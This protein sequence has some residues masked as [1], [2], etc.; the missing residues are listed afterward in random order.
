MKIYKLSL[1]AAAL[2]LTAACSDIDDIKPEGEY[3]SQAQLTESNELAESRK[4]A[5]F[6]GMFTMM[7]QPYYTYG[8]SSDRADDFGFIMSAL[9]N[10]AEG[11]DLCYPNSGY[12]WFSVCGDLT[13]RTS[14]YANLFIRY[15]TPYNQMKIANDLIVYYADSVAVGNA[16][17]INKTAQARAIRAFDYMA[18]APYYQFTY[19][20]SKDK[21]CVPLVTEETTDFTDN[22]RATVEEIYTQVM[23]D[24]DYAIA[25][26]TEDRSDKSRINLNV[27]YGLRARANLVM[28]NYADAAADAE[29]AADGFTPATISEV[30]TPAFC[31][32]SEHN[33]IWGIDMVTA[34]TNNAYATSSSWLS[35]FSSVSYTA[36]AGCFAFINNLL[37]DKI[38]DTDVRK[39]WWV[40]ADLHSPLLS[41]ITW[42][43]VTGDAISTLEIT[44]VKMEFLPYTNVKFGM[45]SGIGS[46]SNDNDWPLMRVE[47]MIL[48][49][50]EGYAKSGNETKARQILSDFVTTYRDPSYTIPSGRTLADEIWFQR[51]VELWGEGFAMS[52]VMRLQKPLVRFHD[53]NSNYPN[54]FRFNLAADDGW[55]LLRFPQRETNSNFALIN[56]S[57]G[58]A[59][60]QDQNPQLRDGVTD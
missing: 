40:D 11:P 43:G 12:N 19:T 60:S 57:D 31:D 55:L 10:D 59:P 51:R 9:S 23:S 50:A 47:E 49:Q 41:T 1:M 14:T 52:D 30:S 27:A 46:S 42:D 18:L 7:G 5:S 44:D 17:A 53:S 34:L 28:G 4:D 48:I 37:Y 54:A 56:N 32:I 16:D 26:L 38:S 2:S 3:L 6:S 13:S 36:G 58:T 45:I 25:N 22:P 21:L 29:K 39:G 8:T 15:A 33:W 20:T 24:L 35:S